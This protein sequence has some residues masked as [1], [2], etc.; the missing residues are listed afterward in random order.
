MTGT[1]TIAPSD[2][3]AF[4]YHEGGTLVLPGGKRLDAERRYLFEAIEDGFAAFFTETPPRLFRR[5]ATRRGNLGRRD[6][7][8][9]RR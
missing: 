4:D 1:A 7:P 8:S 6:H 9:L 5:L 3:G 2:N